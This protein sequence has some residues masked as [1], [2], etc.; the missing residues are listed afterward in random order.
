MAPSF[1]FQT[2]LSSY[3]IRWGSRATSCG[4][5]LA[6]LR[7]RSPS[8]RRGVEPPVSIDAARR[9]VPWTGSRHW[10]PGFS[11]GAG[12]QPRCPSSQR[13]SGP[14]PG[15]RRGAAGQAYTC[16]SSVARGKPPSPCSLMTPR[17]P[18]LPTFSPDPRTERTP[19]T[20]TDAWQ[21]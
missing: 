6:G 5:D 9:Q 21:R 17:L 11:S 12:W 16:S 20:N 15:A 3:A 2:G 7:L 10:G 13:P 19:K 14:R 4:P 1:A 8:T 18:R